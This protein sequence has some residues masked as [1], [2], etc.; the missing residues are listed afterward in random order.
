[1]VSG[2]MQG[3][4]GL[5]LKRAK[6]QLEKS[7]FR[8][9]VIGNGIG[10]TPDIVGLKDGLLYQIEVES[11]KRSRKNLMARIDRQYDIAIFFT[12]ASASQGL[13]RTVETVDISTLPPETAIVP[14]GMPIKTETVRPN[15]DDLES[16]RLRVNETELGHMWKG[17]SLLK[18]AKVEGL[19]EKLVDSLMERLRKP[20]AGGSH[21]RG[22]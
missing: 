10:R 21:Y 16:H 19:D 8:V 9:A 13:V 22:E 3:R 12:K 7:Q 14:P 11:E 4:H 6:E 1:M 2:S 5:L 17:L 18:N 15:E 20:R